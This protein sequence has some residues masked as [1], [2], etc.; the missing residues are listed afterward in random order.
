MKILVLNGPNLNLL[1]ERDATHYGSGTL[2]DIEKS[3]RETFAGD[4]FSFFQSNHEGELIDRIQN[5]GEEFDGL[6]INPG[7]FTHSSVAIRDALE[8]CKIP[9]IE[10]HLSNLAKREDFR[11]N[12]IT[13]TAV[14]G[15]LS[16]FQADGYIGAVYLIKRLK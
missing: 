8:T 4:E 12:Q 15:Y 3:I 1:G 13:T 11:H 14:N 2:S 6:I 16:G 5:S 7:G 9:K 10:V